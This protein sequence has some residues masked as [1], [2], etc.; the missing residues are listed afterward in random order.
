LKNNLANAI[1]RTGRQIDTETGT[2]NANC[3]GIVTQS[4]ARLV[5]CQSDEGYVKEKPGNN[6]SLRH[7]E[8]RVKVVPRFT[9]LA[10]VEKPPSMT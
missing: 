6:D 8:I 10:H 5:L 4:A 9:N 1:N 7:T 2:H 3:V